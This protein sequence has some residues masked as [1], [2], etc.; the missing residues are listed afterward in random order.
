M[1]E[2]VTYAISRV[3]R[4][5]G[6]SKDVL[7][8][9]ER[10]YNFPNPT[11]DANGDRQY[12]QAE[13]ERLLVIKRLMDMGH[14]PGR[15]MTL[16][17]EMLRE[18]LAAIP[19]VAPVRFSQ[20]VAQMLTM[21]RGNQVRQL[22]ERLE[23]LILRYGLELCVLELLPALLKEVGQAWQSGDLMVHHEHLLTEM[24]QNQLRR[25]MGRIPVWA[26]C[27]RVLLATLPDELHGLG[28]LM[29][30][31]LLLLEGAEV[32]NMGLQLPPEE[33]AHA[34]RDNQVDVVCL[35]LSAATNPNLAQQQLARLQLAL[36]EG[37]CV[38]VGGEGARRLQLPA[39]LFERHLSLGDVQASVHGWQQDHLPAA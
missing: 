9:W 16:S 38:W 17:T 12:S 6:L 19:E 20:D 34:V 32:L 21:L 15:L 37:V 31:S 26:I 27:P 13:L 7:R 33:I 4:E 5:T 22:E 25:T 2:A 39:P 29:V 1:A 24:L 28:L 35:S 14:R 3:E 10:R 18:M 8:M 36:P 23:Y 11:R 30:E